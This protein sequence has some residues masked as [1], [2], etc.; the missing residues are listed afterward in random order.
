VISICIPS[1]NYFHYLPYA[2][3]SCLGSPNDFELIVLDNCSS[4]STPTLR[5]RYESDPRVRW[6]RNDRVLPIHENWNKAVSLCTRPFVKMLHADDL[7][8]P[9]AIDQLEEMIQLRPKVAFHGHLADIIDYRGRLIRR[10]P[11]YGEG[12]D[13]V[14]VT[15]AEALRGKLYQRIRFHEP[16]SNMFLKS[17]WEAIGGY[18]GKYRFMMD[19]HFN[20]RMASQFPSA[21]WNRRLVQ[22]RRHRGSDGAHHPMDL[23]LG[24]LKDLAEE[25]LGMLGASATDEDRAAAQGWIEYRLLELCGQRMAFQP[26]QTLK[27][28]VRNASLLRRPLRVQ[29]HCL[30]LLRNKLVDGDPQEPA[31]PAPEAQIQRAFK[32]DLTQSKTR[33]DR[34]TLFMR[35]FWAAC[36]KPLFL[37]LPRPFSKLR[38]ELLRMM[39]ARIGRGCLVEPGVKILMPWNVELGD[40]VAIGRGVEFLNFAPVRIDSMTVV[41]QYCYLCTGT[42]DYTHPHFPLEFSPIVVGA[43]CWI[44]AGAFVGPGVNIGRGA[45]IG[46]RAVVTKNMPAWT[47]CAGNPC[48]P[49]KPREVKSVENIH[50]GTDLNPHPDPQRSRELA[51]LP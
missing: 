3:E 6:I 51:S 45:V 5:E 27:A 23:P 37:A 35:V 7:L 22:V 47:V 19:I 17:A 13:G 36:V 34:R 49:L 50:E 24:N 32:L 25:I 10:Q 48:K 16:S 38:I 11:S 46:A 4:D 2:V 29:R 12:F 18:T 21:V 9:G 44:A 14:E 33:W 28:F 8:K 41:S 31:R 42:H 1:Y 15:G 20:V 43:E 39:G 40:H 30:R 26:A